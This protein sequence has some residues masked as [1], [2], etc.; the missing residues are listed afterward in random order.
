M[1]IISTNAYTG[2]VLLYGEYTVLDGGRAIA[3]PLMTKSCKWTLGTKVDPA[4]AELVRYLLARGSIF[5]NWLDLSRLSEDV[6]DGWYLPSTIPMGYGAGS[7]GSVVAA[8]Y[9]RYSDASHATLSEL[10][11][12]LAHIEGYYHG[13]SS[14][15]DPLVSYRGCS[16]MTQESDLQEV[17]VPAS[18]LHDYRLLDT[19]QPRSTKPQVAWYRSRFASDTTFRNSMIE[20]Q[21]YHDQA[22]VALLDN[23]R[24]DL[25]K[26]TKMISKLQY[27]YL[28]PLIPTHLHH[29]WA[30][31]LDDESITPKL[32]GAGGGGYILILCAKSIPS[33]STMIAGSHI[34]ALQGES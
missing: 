14:G 32:C 22:I 5:H 19:G 10:R 16:I 29:W 6:G 31:T 12:R 1:A 9:G 24:E 3:V 4:L 34:Y 26:V 28:S 30:E 27:Q 18:I 25:D 8:I 17:A 20:L 7:S 13:T 33:E 15:I 11:D 21:S 2:K 23:H